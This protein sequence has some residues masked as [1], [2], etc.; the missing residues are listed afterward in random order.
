MKYYKKILG[1]RIYLSPR[2]SQDYEIFAEWLNDPQV[3]DYIGRSGMLMTN[4]GEKE[5]LEQNNNPE[6]T[7]AIID[8]ETD[9]MVGTVS[10][11]SINH[12]NRCG[13]LGIF[14]GDKDYRD[15]G[16]GTEAIKLILEYGFKYLNLKNINLDL[17]SAN[18]RAYRCYQKCGFKEYGRR[19]KC[20]FING[21]YYDKISM[22]ILD[23]E[24]EGDYI[25]NKNI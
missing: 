10:I 8:L 20:Y 16:Y 23:E 25:R 4:E 11:E 7:F 22:D 3:A 19:R 5:F 6:A 13:T 18:A 1:D 12:L 9:K 15:K 17:V 24:F 2:N 14:I 21:K